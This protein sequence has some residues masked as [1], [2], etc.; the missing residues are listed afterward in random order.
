[1]YFAKTYGPA[2]FMGGRLSSAGRRAEFLVELDVDLETARRGRGGVVVHGDLAV[3]MAGAG[4][5]DRDGHRS[6]HI[7]DRV[8][9]HPARVLEADRLALGVL[10]GLPRRC[11]ERHLG[12]RALVREP[13]GPGRV[14]RERNAGDTEQTIRNLLDDR[15][16]SERHDF[17]LLRLSQIDRPTI[18]QESGVNRDVAEGEIS[19]ALEVSTVRPWLSMWACAPQ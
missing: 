3:Q 14:A 15:C 9:G 11:H 18:H 19:P 1:A 6:G 4:L 7:S 16:T 2:A 12:S 8:D 5:D 13:D 17:L 10:V